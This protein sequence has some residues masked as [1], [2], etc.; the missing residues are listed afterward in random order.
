MLAAVAVL[1][2][3]A[4][5]G[6]WNARRA[7]PRKAMGLAQPDPTPPRIEPTLGPLGNVVAPTAAQAAAR[8]AGGRIDAL[9]ESKAALATEL[10][11]PDDPSLVK[12]F[13]RDELDELLAEE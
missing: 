6:W 3:L 4:A 12:Q 13:S 7:L 2:A 5:H 1:A 8:R 11:R 9:I 10:I